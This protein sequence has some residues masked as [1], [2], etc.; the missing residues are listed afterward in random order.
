[1]DFYQDELFRSLVTQILKDPFAVE[2]NFREKDLASVCE[3]VCRFWESA[4]SESAPSEKGKIENT[5]TLL[6]LILSH[7][8]LSAITDFPKG[9][10]E[11]FS[12]K[13]VFTQ[14]VEELLFE[15]EEALRKAKEE[16]TSLSGEVLTDKKAA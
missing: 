10:I 3:I 4:P 13:A 11:N 15:A 8:D 12:Q 5:R 14:R 9:K 1:M 7:L 2:M 16:L 6:L